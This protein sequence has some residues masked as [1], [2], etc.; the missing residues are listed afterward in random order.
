MDGN[1][2]ALRQEEKDQGNIDAYNEAIEGK[3]EEI[4]ATL[5]SNEVFESYKGVKYDLVD[6]FADFE[7]E[8]DTLA[9]FLNEN[10]TYGSGQYLRN[11]MTKALEAYCEGL[12]KDEIDNEEPPEPHDI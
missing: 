8:S 6:F 10:Q 1:L 3:T 2:C 4:Q 5:L 7:V 12:A 9:E 11:K